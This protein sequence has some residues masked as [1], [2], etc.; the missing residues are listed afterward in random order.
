MSRQKTSWRGGK[1]FKLFI[2]GA[3]LADLHVAFPKAMTGQEKPDTC[4]ST[5]FFTLWLTRRGQAHI[6]PPDL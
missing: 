2:G 3:Q 5:S 6:N 1:E 4:V